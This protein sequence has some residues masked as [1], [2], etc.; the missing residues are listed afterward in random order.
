MAL[1]PASLFYAG[2]PMRNKMKHGIKQAHRK[3]NKNK[4]LPR[5]S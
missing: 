2:V 1:S 3:R 4:L 5:S